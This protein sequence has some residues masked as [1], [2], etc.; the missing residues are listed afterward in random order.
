MHATF[1][2]V[3]IKLR[4][5]QSFCRSPSGIC[6]RAPIILFYLLPLGKM[7]HRQ[8]LHLRCLEE[9]IKEIRVWMVRNRLMFN[10]GKSDF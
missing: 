8:I 1:C 6:L 9:C 2:G 4:P 10:D 7:L 5:Y 3:R